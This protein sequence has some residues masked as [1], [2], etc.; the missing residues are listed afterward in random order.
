MESEG[1]YEVVANG[2]RDT[3]RELLGAA[4]GKREEKTERRGGGTKEVQQAVKGEERSEET[5]GWGKRL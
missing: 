4:S 5:V 3:A 2:I 1:G